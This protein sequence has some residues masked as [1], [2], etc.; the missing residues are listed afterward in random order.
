MNLEDLWI[1]II[2]IVISITIVVVS[3][4]CRI[5]KY[6]LDILRDRYET[7]GKLIEELDDYNSLLAFYEKTP[8]LDISG[9]ERQY[10]KINY[11]GNSFLDR[12]ISYKKQQAEDK[13][14]TVNM[15]CDTVLWQLNDID[16]VALIF[17]LMDNAMEAAVECRDAFIHMKVGYI[18]DYLMLHIQNSKSYD[19]SL[20]FDPI[21][22]DEPVTTKDDTRVHGFGIP[23]VKEL[24]CRYSG[25]VEFADM[26]DAFSVEIMLPKDI[27]LCENHMEKQ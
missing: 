20:S 19:R 6:N 23:V 18:H 26:G 16:T 24:I 3:I 2:V 9:Q 27:R 15:D 5:Q 1:L 8:L 12:M 22:G 13:G 10:K 14:I 25:E 21:R 7:G 11:T 17:N 4:I